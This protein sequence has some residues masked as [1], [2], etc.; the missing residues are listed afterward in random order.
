ML[1]AGGSAVLLKPKRF[2]GW[3]IR[4]ALVV[5]VCSATAAFQVV[6]HRS[7]L[8]ELTQAREA[9]NAKRYGVARQRLSRLAERWT[10][11][12]EVLLLLG[13]CELAMGRRDNALAAWAK[14][15]PS[16]EFFGSAAFSRA[17]HLTE[18]GRYRPAEDLLLE[19]LSDRTV[20]NRL[21]LELALIRLYRNEGRFDSA[22][23]VMRGAWSR[24][25]NPVG[26]L[27]EL[28]SVDFTAKPVEL[29]KSSLDAAD[30]DDDRVWLGRANHAILSG[31]FADASVWLERCLT[32]RPYDG[33]VWQ[34]RLNLAVETG[35]TDGFLAAATHVLANSSD[36]PGLLT[37]RAFLAARLDVPIEEQRALSALIEHEPGNAV[38]LERLAILMS[39]A[40]R[41][42]EAGDLRRRKAEI[43]RIQDQLR[44]IFFDGRELNS[45]AALLADLTAKLGMRF[46]SEAWAIVAEARL[47]DPAPKRSGSKSKTFS[48]FSPPLTVRADALSASFGIRSERELGAGE[49]LADRLA[50][51]RP[52]SRVSV[53]KPAVGLGGNGNGFSTRASVEFVDAAETSG[54]RFVFD[55]GKTAQRL[56]PETMSG[57]VG[58]IDFDGDDWYDVYCPQGGSVAASPGDTAGVQP[59]AGDR[60]FR[61]RRDG[62]FEDVTEKS[63]IA[64]I[65]WGRGYGLGVTVGDYDN[66]GRSDVFCT[67]LMTYALYRNRGD[68]TFEDVTDRVGLA[69]RRDYPTS[70][71][72]AD[73]DNDGDL[74]LYVCHYTIWDPA[75]PVICKNEKGQPLYCHPSYIPPAPDH[76]YRNDDGR[77]VDVTAV[78]GCAEALGRG[79]GVVVADLDGDQRIDVFV[80]NDGSANYLWHNRGGFQFDEVGL[81]AGVAAGAQGGHQAGMGVACGDIDGDGRPDLMVTNFYGEGTTLY[82]NLGDGLF[83]DRSAASGILAATRYL[84]GFGISMADVTNHGCLDVMITNGHVNDNGT[85]YQYAMPSRLYENQAD[86]RLVDISSRAGAPWRAEHIGRAL[87]AGDLDND[88]RVDAVI[89]AQ[90]EPLAF[91]HNQTK[92]I[93]HY[94]T[95]RLEG[96]KSNRDGV[97][98][99]VTI[100]AG[101][102]R[103]VA[104]RCGGG[105][106]Q[107]AHDPRLHFGLGDIGRIDSVVIRWPSGQVDRHTNLAVDTGYVLREAAPGVSALGGFKPTGRVP[108]PAQRHARLAPVQDAVIRQ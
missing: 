81:Q 31:H 78:S 82:H 95:F 61:N 93:G 36:T 11:G 64:K 92:R 90:N 43:D 108:P 10:N 59:A 14:V 56:L 38:A 51:L 7:L 50:D 72:F 15:P 65:A 22:R 42:T 75:H 68:G 9:L 1:Q 84:L 58:L 88:G 45:R 13:N 85:F 39:Q 20:A 104:Q 97:G 41:S 94:V 25:A 2:R 35:D 23:R 91:F 40:G 106:Y 8:F 100:M 101:G 60:L 98:A 83:T 77:F 46:D 76:V 73:L 5:L 29:L 63:G 33:A 12:G 74:D 24:A 34:A 57:G 3:F 55:N 30:R 44:T 96:T 103:Q 26:L 87:A 53:S 69:G 19:T 32:R 89:I 28:W 4:L 66:D 37:Y 67:R 6:R 105:S 48:P 18:A 27:K 21:E 102:R 47:H 54:L 52:A 17:V 79:L 107:S 62:T 99:N 70:A 49:T 71:A 86:G 16:S 80:A